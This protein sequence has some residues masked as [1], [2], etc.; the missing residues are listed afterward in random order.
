[1]QEA[2]GLFG[3][4][5]IDP[6][7]QDPV[8]Y[9]REHVIMLSDWSPLHPHILL[10]KLKQSSGYFNMQKQTLAGLMAGKDQSL[11]D[12]LDWSK[13]RMD[14]ADVSDVTGSTYT[15]LVNGHDTAGNWTGLF[16][17]RER[18]R[19]RIINASSMTNF[20]FRIPGLALT[21]VQADGQDIQP[22][23]VDEFQI[24]IAETYDLIVRPSEQRAYGII[25]EAIDRSGQ[26]RATLAPRRGMAGDVPFFAGA[27]DPDHEGHGHGYA[28]YGSRDHEDARQVASSVTCEDGGPA[29]RRFR[30]CRVIASV[31]GQPA[32]RM[33]II[34]FSPILISRH[35]CRILTSGRHRVRSRYILPPTWNGICGPSMGPSSVKIRNLLFFVTWNG[36]GPF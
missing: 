36:C 9:D 24:G 20:N 3:P 11:S 8:G 32:W 31:T 26:C 25:A 1:M 16:T 2:I 6:D 23:D 10:K 35:Y 18:V 22:V 5:I 33:S 21:I 19:L 7:G 27:P 13:M 34:V 12:R 30:R 14:A 4:I 29:W 15:Y 17:P 28:W